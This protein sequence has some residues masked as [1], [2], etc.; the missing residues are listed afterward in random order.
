MGL[1]DALQICCFDRIKFMS[2]LGS[3]HKTSLLQGG[4]SH[5][6]INAAK[7]LG[8]DREMRSSLSTAIK[9]AL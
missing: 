6:V 3:L 7:E 4:Q 1:N 8:K 9:R 2:G 5:H